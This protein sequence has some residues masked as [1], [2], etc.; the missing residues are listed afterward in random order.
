MQQATTSFN[1]FLNSFVTYY[2]PISGL[3]YAW[4]Y[5]TLKEPETKQEYIA[6]LKKFHFLP[7]YRY[8]LKNILNKID[9]YLGKPKFSKYFILN[10][11]FFHYSF[12]ILYLFIV[13][14]IIWLLGGSNTIGVLEILPKK[15][16]LL[17]KFFFIF[18]FFLILILILLNNNYKKLNINILSTLIPQKYIKFFGGHKIYYS[19]IASI[20]VY[21]LYK[22]ILISI[23]TLIFSLVLN[24]TTLSILVLSLF[25][26]F[27]AI[28]LMCFGISI[29]I[30]V[31]KFRLPSVGIIVLNSSVALTIGIGIYLILS[32]GY[33]FNEYNSSLLVFLL[34]I[35]FLNAILDFISL[36]VSR[37]FSQK[38]ADGESIFLII[39][40]LLLDLILAVILFVGLAYI[41]Y[42]GIELFNALVDKNLQIPIKEMLTDTIKEPFALKNAWITFMLL[43]TLIPT[44][45]HILLAISTFGLQITKLSPFYAKL[46]GESEGR[47]SKKIK[48]ALF[49]ATPTSLIFMLIL[50]GVYRLYLLFI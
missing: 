47:E 15:D 5:A 29:A 7:F 6:K 43:S 10:N 35:P 13:F 16:T 21:I 33:F 19:I 2:L 9:I 32:E 14:L 23:I 46:I 37:Y 41:L 39:F 3:F 48:A 42:Y 27:G 17:D 38:I 24:L 11:I 22:N 1:D 40:H 26:S 20:F 50:Y 8:W 30:S 36:T 28:G 45:L 12:A 34:I 18:L 4:F 49:M 25:F 31:G 44:L